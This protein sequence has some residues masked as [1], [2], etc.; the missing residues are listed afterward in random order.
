VPNGTGPSSFRDGGLGNG[1]AATP[2][3]GDQGDQGLLVAACREQQQVHPAVEGGPP[4]DRVPRPRS[5]SDEDK[6]ARTAGSTSAPSPTKRTRTSTR[7]FYDDILHR[8]TWIA[9][10]RC[11]FI[12]AADPDGP[13]DPPPHAAP[14]R[15]LTEAGA[16]FLINCIELRNIYN[17]ECDLSFLDPIHS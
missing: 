8:A 9:E 16:C 5:L 4:E 11:C 15:R 13:D 1:Q 14:T 7:P 6:T 10:D 2:T 17:F 3:H 12:E